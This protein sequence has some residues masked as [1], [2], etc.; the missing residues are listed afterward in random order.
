MWEDKLFIGQYNNCA[1]LK[2]LNQKE[3]E[4]LIHLKLPNGHK[5]A[6]V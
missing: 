1:K 6:Y 4:Y 2:D 5:T 3:K